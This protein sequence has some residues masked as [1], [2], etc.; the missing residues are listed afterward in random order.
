MSKRNHNLKPRKPQRLGSL[1]FSRLEPRR[2]LAAQPINFAQSIVQ[3]YYFTVADLQF[4]T[5][6]A[7]SDTSN[8]DCSDQEHQTGQEPDDCVSI[9]VTLSNFHFD[10]FNVV[11]RSDVT[12][13][14][15]ISPNGRTDAFGFSSNSH[16]GSNPD[17]GS[18]PNHG[19]QR[20]PSTPTSTEQPNSASGDNST[21]PSNLHSGFL[22][23]EDGGMEP[24]SMLASNMSAIDDAYS[25]LSL[26]IDHQSY[27]SEAD[28]RINEDSSFGYARTG[29]LDQYQ[30]FSLIDL[31]SSTTQQSIGTNHGTIPQQNISSVKRLLIAEAKIDVP[32]NEQRNI[33]QAD[34]DFYFHI[35]DQRR[36]PHQQVV[37]TSAL[38]T[39]SESTPDP[40]SPS[41][42]PQTD[43]QNDYYT[44]MDEEIQ[45]IHA[46]PV[47]LA[48]SALV[49]AIL[50]TN[51]R[52]HPEENEGSAKE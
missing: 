31:D 48:E 2:M 19:H 7:Q 42:S 24:V 10:L 40:P 29:L 28:D 9:A 37:G 20:T 44:W 45:G 11:G 33:S 34:V 27:F 5:Q 18:G 21:S 46:D 38:V 14:G 41:S 3:S 25:S 26:E 17:R 52:Q 16:G 30:T 43:D 35:S 13:S 8:N 23:S 49:A 12:G 36:D 1:T 51:F 32:P 47:P 39:T 6:G 22:P 15:D 50:V 4:R